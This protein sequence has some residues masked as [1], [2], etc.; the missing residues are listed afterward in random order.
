MG[1]MKVFKGKTQHI[2]FKEST[3]F[4][5]CFL[6][7]KQGLDIIIVNGDNDNNQMSFTFPVPLKM[8]IRKLLFSVFPYIPEASSCVVYCYTLIEREEVLNI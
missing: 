6:M 8:I 7:F 4:L 3:A 5:N 1:K 2:S